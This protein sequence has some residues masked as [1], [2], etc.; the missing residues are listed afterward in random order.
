MRCPQL[1]KMILHA[2]ERIGG[3]LLAVVPHLTA[4]DVCHPAL[5]LAKSVRGAEL[6]KSRH[7]HGEIFLARLDMLTTGE[8]I[9]RFNAPSCDIHIGS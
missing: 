2:A 7:R 8:A 5:A 6:G 3:E 1:G 9:E 4:L